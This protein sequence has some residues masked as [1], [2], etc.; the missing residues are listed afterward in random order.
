MIRLQLTLIFP[1]VLE[2]EGE[3]GVFPFHDADLSE[4]SLPY[5]PKQSEVIQV[6]YAG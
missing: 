6:D 2:G 1:N 5:H 4:R 3:S